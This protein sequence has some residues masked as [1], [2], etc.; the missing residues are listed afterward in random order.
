MKIFSLIAASIIAAMLMVATPAS[1]QT[2]LQG[3]V[4]TFANDLSLGDMTTDTFSVSVSHKFES[5][6]NLAV[7]YTNVENV[8]DIFTV[9]YRV[10]GP[11][12][13]GFVPYAAVGL[14]AADFQS[15]RD[16]LDV[17]GTLTGGLEYNLTDN[18][19]VFVDYTQ[20]YSPSVRSRTLGDEYD[21]GAVS[22]G[23]NVRF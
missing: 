6:N 21:R 18:T 12:V 4:G 15:G 8:A 16:R 5:G 1:A 14:G 19:A 7:V 11:T 3:S 10:D 9:R 17:V 23:L 22:V 2:R 13:V 20:V